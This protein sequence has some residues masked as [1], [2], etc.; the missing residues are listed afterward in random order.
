MTK[1][2][3]VQVQGKYKKIQ[4]IQSER[5]EDGILIRTPVLLPNDPGYHG[6]REDRRRQKDA[7]RGSQAFMLAL[8]RAQRG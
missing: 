8:Q 3:A 6:E 5:R 1:N 4:G 7:E 2:K